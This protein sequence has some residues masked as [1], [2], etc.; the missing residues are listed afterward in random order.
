MSNKETYPIQGMHCASCAMKIENSLK[1]V[2]SV[3]NAV[4]NF[5]SEKATVESDQPI[6][7]EEVKKAVEKVGYKI[8]EEE[9]PPP[10][11]SQVP[12]DH[13]SHDMKGG[14]HDH[15]AMLK[16]DEINKLK[17]KLVFGI[18]ISVLVLV[19]SMEKIFPFVENI[20]QQTRFFILFI[21]TTPVMFWSGQQFF[22][23][24]W[25]GLKNFSANMDTLVAM[26]TGA[27]Y[28]YSTVAMLFPSLFESAGREIV[29]Y[30]DTSAIIITLIILGKFLEARAKKGAGEAIKKLAGLQAK[31]ARIIKD[32]KEIDIAIEQVQKGD[33]II[34][35]PG[36]KIPVDGKII[37]GE[38][39]IDESMITGE[40]IPVAKKIGDEVI[41]A[42]IN[43]TGSFTFEATKVGEETAL[44]QIVKMVEDAQG[45]K[46]PIQRLADLIS[47]YFVPI[48]L[49]IAIISFVVWIIAGPAPTLT[50]AL[51]VAVTVMIIACPCALGLAT[52]TAIMVGTGKGAEHGILIKDAE[53]LERAGKINTIV[54]D[55]TGTLT[56]GEPSVVNILSVGEKEI[57]I[58]QFAY[59]LEKKSEHP[60]ALAIIERAEKKNLR[61]LPIEQFKAIVG[62]GVEGKIDGKN[63]HLGNQIY[64]EEQ[65]INITQEQKEAIAKEEKEG[66]TALALAYNGNYLGFISVADEIRKSS[67]EA[68]QALKKLEITPVMMTGD[69]PKTAQAVAGKLGIEKF[70]AR[71]LPNEKLEKVKALQK[72]GKTV[73]MVGD[74]INDAP[75]LV[76]ADIG[77][78]IS[79]GTDIAMESAGVTVLR[80]DLQ[81]VV[82]MIELSRKTMRTIK[83]NLFWAFIYN[84]IGIPIAAGVLYPATGVLLNPMIA[85]GAMA[86]SSI[87]VVLNSLRLKRVKI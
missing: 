41:G 64:L 9:K 25:R 48:V 85:S 66:R 67:I 59:S 6:D 26:G 7:K 71:V 80:G 75:A 22:V 17:K 44:A 79:S 42:T 27:A 87:F 56:K 4:V 60:L 45:S 57:N 10:N 58:L 31:T 13:S 78:A 35:R 63:S 23:G 70:E 74:G 28:L 47:G 3:E 46:A 81:K 77:I 65:G 12:M 51:I 36:E 2:P 43:K 15:V 82:S 83:G 14:E 72:E 38:S 1:K 55:K 5:A 18:I 69:N 21:L 86:F 62:R 16:K 11:H 68:I 8:I 32:S 40:S 76:Q 50:F 37:E 54:F 29:V 73:A 30:F 49:T 20:P 24:A 39:A 34:V 52:P 61:A 84:I 19:G 53:T 33:K